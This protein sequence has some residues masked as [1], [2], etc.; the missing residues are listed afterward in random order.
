MFAGVHAVPSMYLR[1][2]RYQT[3]VFERCVDSDQRFTTV[4]IRVSESN[5]VLWIRREA[6]Y[7]LAK[8]RVRDTRA[9]G[10]PQWLRLKRCGVPTPTVVV[11]SEDVLTNRRLSDPTCDGT[12]LC[13]L[14]RVPKSACI[15]V[16]HAA[17][18][19]E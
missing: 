7:R 4:H 15:L 9:P 11:F 3:G 19:F 8:S 12:W 18:P 17:R 16:G 14:R 5:M 2:G 13:W 6:S 10:A 1:N